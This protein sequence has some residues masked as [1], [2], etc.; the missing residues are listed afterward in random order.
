MNAR[1][2]NSRSQKK[3]DRRR[4]EKENTSTPSVT[5]KRN[6]HRCRNMKECQGKLEWGNNL[7]EKYL[8][9]Q[10]QTPRTI[11]S[12]GTREDKNEDRIIKQ[13]E[14]NNQMERI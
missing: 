1:V 9:D 14:Q 6:E 10:E 5:Q 11:T 2:E 12:Y 13:R 7:I 8:K 3:D 4:H